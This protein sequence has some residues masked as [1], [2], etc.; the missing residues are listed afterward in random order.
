MAHGSPE[1]VVADYWSGYNW[2]AIN[3]VYT[4]SS[5]YSPS[6]TQYQRTPVMPFMMIESTYENEYG[7]YHDQ[8]AHRRTT[9]CSPARRADLR[10]QPD[11]ALRWPGRGRHHPDLATGTVER[12]CGEHAAPRE[13]VQ[14]PPLVSTGPGQRSHHAYSRVRER[15]QFRGRLPNAGGGTVLVYTPIRKALTINMTRV[16]HPSER[17]VV[18]SFDRRGNQHW[19]LRDHRVTCVHATDQH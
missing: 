13:A 3:A 18:Q 6:V 10:E 12:G 8:L 16:G 14:L 4:Y 17:M 15:E 5:T 2:M 9:R 1:S 11:V 7:S 19:R